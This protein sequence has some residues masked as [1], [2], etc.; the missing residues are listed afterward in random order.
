MDRTESLNK[1]A[2]Q[3]EGLVYQYGRRSDIVITFSKLTNEEIAKFNDWDRKRFCLIPGEEC[4]FVWEAQQPG[5]P[6]TDHLLYVVAV[7]GD[8]LLTAAGEL[9]NL[10]SR[11]F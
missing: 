8:S 6:S 3:I 5:S 9:M 2:T 1:I 11:K 7:T 4:F 10:V